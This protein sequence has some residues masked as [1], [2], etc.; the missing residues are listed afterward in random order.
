MR[1]AQQMAHTSCYS[2]SHAI[3]N[4][5]QFLSIA[6][7]L[8]VCTQ[9]VTIACYSRTVCDRLKISKTIAYPVL[10]TFRLYT[11]DGIRLA[12]ASDLTD[13]GCYVVVGK[14]TGGFKYLDY[15]ARRPRF[16]VKSRIST[17]WVVRTY[18]YCIWYFLMVPNDFE[19]GFFYLGNKFEFYLKL[20]WRGNRIEN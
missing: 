1:P 6:H 10:Y 2:A 19:F 17:P 11:L 5:V 9:R 15:A 8:F 20:N 12:K 4:C 18:D 13:G 7:L 3:R 16:R 14:E